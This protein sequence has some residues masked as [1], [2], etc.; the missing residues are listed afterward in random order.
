MLSRRQSSRLRGVKRLSGGGGQSLKL[1][2][3]TAVFKKVSFLIGVPS[4]SL[5]RLLYAILGTEK[6]KF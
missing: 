3:K 1:S 2:T 6:S 4:M 5:G